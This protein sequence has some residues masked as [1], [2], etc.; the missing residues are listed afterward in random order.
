MKVAFF[1]YIKKVWNACW[2]DSTVKFSIVRGLLHLKSHIFHG[3]YLYTQ[4][5]VY[6]FIYSLHVGHHENCDIV[7]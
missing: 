4:F 5:H 1:A 7:N 3:E 2:Q 6:V